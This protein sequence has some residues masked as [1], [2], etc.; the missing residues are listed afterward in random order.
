MLLC[1]NSLKIPEGQPEV[2]IW[3]RTNNHLQHATQKTTRLNNTN[4]LKT[5]GWTQVLREGKQFQPHSWYR[6]VTV[7]ILQLPMQSVP[8]TTN[9]M[10][11]NPAHGEVYTRYNIFDK[12]C[13]WLVAGRM[14]F[15]VSSTNKLTAMI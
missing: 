14:F 6:W 8:I 2:A 1:K 3:R 7:K 12:V 15:P 9:V 13:H 4:P 10:R 11:S 5:G